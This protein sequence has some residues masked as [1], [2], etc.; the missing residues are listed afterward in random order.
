MLPLGLEL[1]PWRVASPNKPNPGN[2]LRVGYLG[3]LLRHKGVHILVRAFHQLRT[4]GSTLQIYGFAMPGDPFMSQLRRLVSQDPRVKLMGRYHQKD[5]PDILSRID[6]IVIPSLW[7]ETFSIV[8]REALLSGTP[9]VASEIGAF[10]RSSTAG[11]TGYSCLSA[12]TD[13]L[14]DALHSL[15]TD[16]DLLAHLREGALLSAKRIKSMDDHVH[17]VDL[18]YESL[19]KKPRGSVASWHIPAFHVDAGTRLR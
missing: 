6:V 1:S 12:I 7:H 10:P 5:L 2:G 19:A 11:R 9:V 16:P 14:H 4:P 15:S 8:A 18:L 3:S 17:E 13:A